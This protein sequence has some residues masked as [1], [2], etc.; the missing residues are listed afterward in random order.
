MNSDEKQLSFDNV[1]IFEFFGKGF[2]EIKYFIDNFNNEIRDINEY[3]Y[4]N[5]NDSGISF[6]MKNCS[7]ESIYLYNQ[8]IMKFN[9]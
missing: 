6:C 9:R 1:N 3:R 5:F 4:I 2:D 8:N 7:I